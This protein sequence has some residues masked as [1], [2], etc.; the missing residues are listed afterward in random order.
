MWVSGD[1]ARAMDMQE[2]EVGRTQVPWL[3]LEFCFRAIKPE[4]H[5]GNSSVSNASSHVFLGSGQVVLG[6]TSENWWPIS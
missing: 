3:V 4:V 5:T 2:E 1:G 6:K